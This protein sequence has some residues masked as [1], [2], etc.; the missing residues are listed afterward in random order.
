MQLTILWVA[1]AGIRCDQN[2]QMDHHS[3]Q[4]HHGFESA[5]RD[6]MGCG[7]CQG[8]AVSLLILKKLIDL[9]IEQVGTKDE[10]IT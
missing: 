4:R 8:E 9:C 2:T 10:S 7:G 3:V 6:Q 5:A 1:A